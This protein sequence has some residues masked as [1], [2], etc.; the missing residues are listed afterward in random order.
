MRIKRCKTDG[1]IPAEVKG[2]AA[3]EAGL[4]ESWFGYASI[5]LVVPGRAGHEIDLVVVTPE[6]IIL[7]D[8]KDWRGAVTS[9]KDLWFQR[10]AKRGRSPVTKLREAAR[11]V[12]S[13]LEQ[14]LR[15]RRVPP[16]YID[17][18]VVFTSDCD[19]SALPEDQRYYIMMLEDFVALGET[20]RYNEVFPQRQP[21]PSLRALK[22]ELDTFF[23]GK[24]FKPQERIFS[25]YKARGGPIFVHPRHLFQEYRADDVSDPNYT[26]LL[27]LWDLDRLPP[28]LRT[29]A[30]RGRMATREKRALGFLQSRLPPETADGLAL[31]LLVSDDAQPVS[32]NY[33]ELYALRNTQRRLDEFLERHRGRLSG[34]TRLRLISVLLGKFAAIHEAG[35]A[36]RDLGEH[37]IW[38]EEPHLISLSGFAT[39]TFP[40]IQTVGEY[41]ELLASGGA[42][43]PE[44][45]LADGVGDPFRR[46]VF[47]MG[48][49]LARL[50]YE[51]PLI[52]VD[53]VAEL[54]PASV[55]P[56]IG[57]EHRAWLERALHL[58]P[59]SRHA[60][61]QEMRRAYEAVAKVEE[62]VVDLGE[63]AQHESTCI[64][65]VTFP[66]SDVVR[67][68]RSSQYRSDA[69]GGVFVKV[70]N[71]VTV[72]SAT[73]NQ[74]VLANFL[75][76]ASELQRRPIA[77]LAPI[78]D[79]GIGPSGLFL[80][81]TFVAAP[82]LAE[83]PRSLTDAATAFAFLYELANTVRLLHD[84][85]LAHG[86]IKPE[87]VLVLDET[88]G[89]R[90][91]LVDVVDYSPGGEPRNSAYS[92]PKQLAAPAQRRDCWALAKIAVEVLDG[93]AT[94]AGRDD[95]QQ[96]RDA[97]ASHL[98]DDAPGMSSTNELL[99]LFKPRATSSR[100]TWLIDVE[101]PSFEDHDL[102]A[103]D[104]RL[105]LVFRTDGRKG[106]HIA[107]LFGVEERVRV[108]WHPDEEEARHARVY[109]V[110]DHQRRAA[111]KD[112]V[113]LDVPRIRIRAKAVAGASRELI[114]ALR[115]AHKQW[116]PTP[117]S[118]FEKRSPP[119]A[120]GR[121]PQGDSRSEA[122]PGVLET[123]LPPEIAVAANPAALALP[124]IER[125]W[126]KLVEAEEQILPFVTVTGV[127]IPKDDYVLVPVQAGPRPL[128]FGDD[129]EVTVFVR[130][131]V[132]DDRQIGRLD[133]PN[134]HGSSLAIRMGAKRRHLGPGQRLVFRAVLDHQSFKRRSQA[135]ERVVG[136]RAEIPDLI[137]YFEPRN[138]SRVASHDVRP[139]D[140]SLARYGLNDVQ[141][142]A[143]RKIM[144]TGPL[145][146]LQGPPGTG[147]TRFIG[148]LVHFLLSRGHAQ[149][150]LF[151]GQSHVA[152][153][154][155]AEK[156]LDFLQDEDPEAL[157]RIGQHTELSER[158]KPYHPDT[159]R[160]AYRE[161]FRSSIMARVRQM[162]RWL[163][164]PPG[165]VEAVADVYVDLAGLVRRAE[166]AD[167]DDV[168]GA[169]ELLRRV[170]SAKYS[171]PETL[172]PASMVAHAVSMAAEEHHVRSPA[173][174]RRTEELVTLA[175]EWVGC[176]ATT[177]SFDEFLAR[178]RRVVCG[179]CVGVGR[180]RL[181]IST[182]QYD[183][184]IV[185]E[186]AR[187][188]PGELAVPLQVGRRVLLV[189]D[190][191]QLPPMYDEGVLDAA[192]LM[193]GVDAKFLQVSDFE[194]VFT[195]DYG[196]SV[197][198]TLVAQYRMAP[199]IGA[200]VSEV[201]YPDTPLRTA[202]AAVEDW[203][204]TLPL[205]LGADVVWLDTSRLEGARETPREHSYTNDGEIDIIIELLKTLERQDGY[206]E[207][208]VSRAAG[209]GPPIGIIC[210]YSAQ[211]DA[212]YRRLS[213]ALLS[214]R[215]RQLVRVDTVDAYQGHQNVVVIVSLVRNNV[216]DRQGF[217]LGPE[218]VNVALSRA[219]DK[220]VIVGAA[221]MWSSPGSP[222]G[223][224]LG[225][226]VQTEAPN[227]VR[228]V[229][230]RELVR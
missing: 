197:G 162:S 75:R 135:V 43:L 177:K 193:L 10:G 210:M 6:R 78:A 219:Q 84:R 51:A 137:S 152:V 150:I 1:V 44:D 186:A 96:M 134:S 107:D 112:A 56:I 80:A 201:F 109:P 176:L 125:V 132:G 136:R 146:L 106:G 49:T 147:K 90:P 35:L 202:R 151:V 110:F 181:G 161:L 8:L 211:R 64:P 15:G 29:D 158:L 41:R 76:S 227:E 160:L 114:A 208:L 138:T 83:R 196:R 173:A 16:P 220:L 143:F 153:N 68:G 39:A 103:E 209:E 178:T 58:D 11:E 155:G 222:L 167:V 53:G 188:A 99:R 217:L 66:P 127:P 32:T 194:R 123:L 115:Q 3:A 45:I 18:L 71:G 89:V 212:L 74:L 94:N 180:S 172:E 223:R 37:S 205:G 170:A 87:H 95:I 69:A 226:I 60:D 73:K 61:A 102:L 101:G 104:G 118:V 79:F 218:R 130:L 91:I 221:Q 88:A 57:S 165:F 140:D 189:G 100:T 70:W 229:D 62:V 65:Y 159:L 144:C 52:M 183:W 9:E 224:V 230:A 191:R 228:L 215:L 225:R 2:L 72:Q 195:S 20:K 48:A 81:T 19:L 13:R 27:R 124:S 203:Q 17:L 67:Q 63:I 166:S 108:F 40:D 46:D 28:E 169:L 82:S 199:A 31:R 36:H 206:L 24:D 122:D 34:E 54:P 93:V 119:V 164:V 113:L 149:N 92:S 213:K 85:G 154:S 26:A 129:E 105:L 30:E 50:A 120:R 86:D 126:A 133:L 163:G 22:S 141:R 77:G 47:S 185:D 214:A 59:H 198:T 128:E 145:G 7:V 168:Q 204:R 25:S 23:C 187:C 148:A 14:Q 182:A 97:I 33:F 116:V 139:D 200:L 131:A 216:G 184:V 179:T 121:A 171:L 111:G 98:L 21:G 175:K 174:V 117:T 42:P 192:S 142:D 55:A 5:E 12:K 4:P 38:V 157:T 207:S 190:H 156:I